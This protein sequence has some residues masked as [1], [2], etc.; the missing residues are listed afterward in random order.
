METFPRN[1]QKIQWKNFKN[2]NLEVLF[3]LTLIKHT[4][5]ETL[6]KDFLEV[7]KTKDFVNFG[8]D[9]TVE[10]KGMLEC[11]SKRVKPSLK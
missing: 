4:G 6:I 10:E 8:G 9:L 11:Y 7:L 2:E 1:I 3:L 5:N